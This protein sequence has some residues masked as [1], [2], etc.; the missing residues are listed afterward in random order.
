MLY[1][2][3]TD[4]SNIPLD[5]CPKEAKKSLVT[6]FFDKGILD[7]I[8]TKIELLKISYLIHLDSNQMD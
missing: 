1:H 3:F 5:H 2:P 8:L 4:R 7:H 6:V